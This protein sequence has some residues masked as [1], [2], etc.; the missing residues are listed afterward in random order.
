MAY[1]IKNRVFAYSEDDEY[2]Y[3]ATITQIESDDIY[4]RY[5]DGEEE[6]TTS[7]YL[8][9]LEVAV[10]DEVESLWSEDEEYYMAEVLEV[11]GEQV[12]IQWEDDES[13]EWTTLSALRSWDDE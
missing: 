3:P 6:W 1:A 8:S 13:E 5:D 9:P 2:Y 11:K 12:R 10:G 4:I 7:D